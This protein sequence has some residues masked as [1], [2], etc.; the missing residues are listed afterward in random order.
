MNFSTGDSAALVALLAA[1][2][3]L[4]QADK[5]G[6]KL[7][8]E[9]EG[10]EKKSGEKSRE[11]NQLFQRDKVWTLHLIVTPEEWKKIEPPMLR[12]GQCSILRL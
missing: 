4:A 1:P 10:K 11:S 5:P 9:T 7:E 12:L 8:K 6:A 2:C 3:A